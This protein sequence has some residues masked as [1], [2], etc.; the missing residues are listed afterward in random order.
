[1]ASMIE[2]FRR[3]YPYKTRIINIAEFLFQGGCLGCFHCA[4]EGKCVYKDGFDTFLR[5]EIQTASAIVYAFSIK[6][7]SMGPRFKNASSVT[8]TAQ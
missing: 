6:N 1:M 2:D 4:G 5:Q 3:G 7:H 8:A